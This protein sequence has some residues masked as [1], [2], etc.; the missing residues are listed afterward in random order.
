MTSSDHPFSYEYGLQLLQG[1]WKPKI[2]SAVFF[3][4][5]PTYTELRNYLKPI[6]DTVLSQNLKTLI[7]EGVVKKGPI[8]HPTQEIDGYFLTEKGEALVPVLH[9]LCRWTYLFTDEHRRDSAAEPCLKCPIRLGKIEPL[10]C[11][12]DY[13]RLHADEEKA[14]READADNKVKIRT[15]IGNQK[16]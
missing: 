7:D 2:L 10:Q 13:H 3:H 14:R 15:K 12:A 5:T 11:A 4:R 1:K 9:V 6:S 16:N 8:P